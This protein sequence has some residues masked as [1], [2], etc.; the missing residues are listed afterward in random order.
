MTTHECLV[1]GG[2]TDIRCSAE[3]E[4]DRLR[5]V[6][7]QNAALRVAL[8]EQRNAGYK[9]AGIVNALLYAVRDEGGVLH[10]ADMLPEHV[11][12]PFVRLLADGG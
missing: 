1:C 9:L 10:V 11:R 3:T 6:E 8:E 4:L 12:G 5:D 7:Q 2:T